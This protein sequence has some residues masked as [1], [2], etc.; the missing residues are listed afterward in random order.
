[1]RVSQTDY[2]DKKRETERDVLVKQDK[3]T[4]AFLRKVEERRGERAHKST[5]GGEIVAEA[6]SHQR[7]QKD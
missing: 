1:M 2:L 6:V 4:S 3:S 5:G 7:S